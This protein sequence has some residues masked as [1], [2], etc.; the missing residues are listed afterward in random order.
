MFY[1][2]AVLLTIFTALKLKQITLGHETPRLHL[3]V[4]SKHSFTLIAFLK[5]VLFLLTA[6]QYISVSRNLPLIF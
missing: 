5:F 4:I 2:C 3:S 6:G 1:T